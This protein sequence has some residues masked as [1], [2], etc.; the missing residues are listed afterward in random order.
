VT[1]GR[2]AAA[3][4]DGRRADVVEQ[5][6]LALR[7]GLVPDIDA[8]TAQLAAVQPRRRFASFM[9]PR[10]GGRADTALIRR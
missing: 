10:L 4:L 9:P 7:L 8:V 5:A 1:F 2:P 3:R 6:R